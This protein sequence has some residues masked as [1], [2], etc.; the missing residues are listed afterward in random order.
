MPNHYS[1]KQDRAAASR[2]GT[3]KKTVNV[4]NRKIQDARVVRKSTARFKGKRTAQEQDSAAASRGGM[5]PSGRSWYR[6]TPKDTDSEYKTFKTG[7]QPKGWTRV[8]ASQQQAL[9]EMS[10]RKTKRGR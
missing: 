7:Q 4:S 2:G 3:K 8:P 6:V 9:R 1:K 5:Q 10:I